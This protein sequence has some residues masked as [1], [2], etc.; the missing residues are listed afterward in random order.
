[1]LKTAEVLKSQNCNYCRLTYADDFLFLEAMLLSDAKTM[2]I[3]SDLKIAITTMGGSLEV[4]N[5]QE[6]ITQFKLA[7]PYEN[8]PKTE[9]LLSGRE[10]EVIQLLANGLR[11]REIAAKLFISDRTVK[12]H[13]NNVVNKLKAK[14]RIQAIHQVYS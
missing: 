12:F 5:F 2:T 7:I 11:D 10:Q 13:I 6:N 9:T 4:D 1:M 14:T 8:Q 3:F